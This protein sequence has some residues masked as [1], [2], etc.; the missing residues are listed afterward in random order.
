MDYAQW[1][2]CITNFGH[3]PAELDGT[4]DASRTPSP[5]GYEVNPTPWT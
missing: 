5:V 3:S 1:S 4:G 2:I